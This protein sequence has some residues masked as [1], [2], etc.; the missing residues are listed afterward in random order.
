MQIVKDFLKKNNINDKIIAVGVS[1]GA[2]SLALAIWAAENAKSCG[3]KIVALTVDHKLRPESTDEALYVAKV[4]KKFGVEHHI[5]TWEGE[6]PQNSIEEAARTARYNLIKNWCFAN[7]IKSVMI[8]HHQLDQA[9]TF[10]MRLLRGSGLDGLCGMSS[11]SDYE[12]LQILRPFLQTPPQELKNFLN[13]KNIKWME[14][15]SNQNEDFLR[16]KIRKFLPILEEKI[17][18]DAE[19]ITKAMSTLSRSKAYLEAQT[20]KFIKNNCKNIYDIAMSVSCKTLEDAH[21]EIVYRF[22][23][24]IL[25]KIG[26]RHYQPRAEDVL[27]LQENIKKPSFRGATLADCEIFKSQNRIWIVPE[28][29]E[30]SIPKKKE[31]ELFLEKFPELKKSKIPGKLKKTLFYRHG[32]KR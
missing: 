30:H 12:G 15:S 2:D 23:V 26:K 31:W 32:E 29:K 8:A 7:G 13:K 4:M 9:E 25:K 22:F 17:D 6:K 21:E 19:K 11:V 10:F 3:V 16:V 18:L 14:D 28:D 24:N 20:E 5:L 1:G 27:R